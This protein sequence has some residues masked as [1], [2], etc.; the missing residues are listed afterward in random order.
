MECQCECLKHPMDKFDLKTLKKYT[1]GDVVMAS[2]KKHY[3][4]SVMTIGSQDVVVFDDEGRV[5]TKK[6]RLEQ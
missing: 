4:A 5:K 6:P 3:L 1:G 2:D